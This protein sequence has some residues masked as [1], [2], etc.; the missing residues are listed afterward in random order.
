MLFY[1]V[2]LYELYKEPEQWKKIYGDDA[3]FVPMPKDPDADEYYI[4][5][6]MEAYTFI[7]GGA[8]PEGVARFLDCKRFSRMN[9]DTR[10]LGDEQFRTDY[11]WTDEM[12]EMQ[13][14]M[15]RLADENPVIDFSLA[16]NDDCST[17]LDNELRASSHGTPWNETYDKISAQV[18]TLIEDAN[19]KK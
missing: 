3:F 7:K 19:K 17:I 10:D 16:V 9:E 1:P 8:N 14:E 15:Q 6:G 4:P 18:A 2:G 11:G 5:V 13:N 12:V